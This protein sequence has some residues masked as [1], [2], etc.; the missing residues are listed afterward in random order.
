MYVWLNHSD[1]NN[2]N[3]IFSIVAKNTDHLFCVSC[4][5]LAPEKL[6]LFLLSAGARIDD[7]ELES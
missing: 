6:L 2:H 1:K 7:I 3:E 5:L 4:E